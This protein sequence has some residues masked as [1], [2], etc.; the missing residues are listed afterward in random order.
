MKNVK[1]KLNLYFSSRHR[2]AELPGSNDSGSSLLDRGDKLC[3]EPGLVQ[4]HRGPVDGGLGGVGELRGGVVAPDGHLL[5][6][7]DGLVQLGRQLCCSSVLVQP[8]YGEKQTLI[9]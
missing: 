7:G 5:D 2:T 9:I 6:G 3:L 8:R 4:R 1:T